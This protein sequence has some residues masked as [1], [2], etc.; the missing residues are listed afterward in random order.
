MVGG[1]CLL[2]EWSDKAIFCLLVS[3]ISDCDCVVGEGLDTNRRPF[4]VRLPF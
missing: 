3:S 2:T 4:K 1:A